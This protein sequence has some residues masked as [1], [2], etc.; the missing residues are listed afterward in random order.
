MVQKMLIGVHKMQRMASTLPF[1]KRCHKDSNAFLNHI[2]RVI[3]DKTWVSFV[4]V[5]TKEQSKQ[6]MHTFTKQATKKF[7]K[8]CLPGS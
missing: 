2:V 4:K 1:S 3:G 6:W 7:K 5:D 8:C